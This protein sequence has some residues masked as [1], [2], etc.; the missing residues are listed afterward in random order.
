MLPSSKRT[1]VRKIGFPISRWSHSKEI[2]SSTIWCPTARV[3][4]LS[5]S[6]RT[7]RKGWYCLSISTVHS[8]ASLLAAL[9][10]APP[11]SSW[12]PSFKFK[13]IVGVGLLHQFEFFACLFRY[14]FHGSHR[15][16]HAA[17]HVPVLPARHHQKKNPEVLCELGHVGGQSLGLLVVSN[18]YGTM[19]DKGV[20]L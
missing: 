11:G 5:N 10:L 9:R 20:A 19:S 6:L 16:N 8:Q 12:A 18:H 17:V 2:R 13:T 14:R 1:N 3:C 15:L 7:H 4:A